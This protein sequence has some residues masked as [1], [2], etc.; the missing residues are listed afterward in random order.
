VARARGDGKLEALRRVPLFADLGKRDLTAV[1][2]IPDEVD[3]P[4]GKALIRAGEPG[5]QFFLLL[6]GKAVVRRNGR[7]VNTLVAGDFFGEISLLTN[8]Q[9]TAEVTTSEPSRIAVITRPAFTALMRTHPSVQAKVVQAL[10][11]RL[12]GD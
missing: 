7:K 9:T 11:A 3:V 1:G 6:E 10:C 2:R 8:R 5:R 4:G 12:P